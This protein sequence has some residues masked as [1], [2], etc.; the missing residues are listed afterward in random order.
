MLFCF[1]FWFWIVCCVVVVLLIY[2]FKVMFGYGI[3]FSMHSCGCLLFTC[4]LDIGGCCGWLFGCFFTLFCLLLAFCV[5]CWCGLNCCCWFGCCFLVFCDDWFGCLDFV[6]ICWNSDWY[7]LFWLCLFCFGCLFGGCF[8]LFCCFGSCLL[9][10]C[11]W[12]FGF[13]LCLVILLNSVVYIVR[14]DGCRFVWVVV[15]L[16]WIWFIC[17]LVSVLLAY[18][19]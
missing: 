5:C 13:M 11:V 9:M 12:T 10:I 18:L 8:M 16:C 2:W 14:C 6:V 4:Y 3:R 7:G 19:I 17:V 1:V 15:L